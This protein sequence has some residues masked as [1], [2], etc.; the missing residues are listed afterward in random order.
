MSPPADPELK[1]VLRAVQRAVGERSWPSPAAQVV[2][3]SLLRTLLRGDEVP[4]QAAWAGGLG[5]G[6]KAL[7]TCLA[8]LSLGGL[9]YMVDRGPRP[10]AYLPQTTALEA[11]ARGQMSGPE[12]MALS[13][14]EGVTDGQ[15]S[16]PGGV[17]A[18][19]RA[20]VLSSSSSPISSASLDADQQRDLAAW[21]A[22][23]G[24]TRVDAATALAEDRFEKDV[25]RAIRIIREA[26]TKCPP[27]V[28][29]TVRSYMARG[30][31]LADLRQL[32]V[33]I[34]EYGHAAGGIAYWRPALDA[35][36]EARLEGANIV[37]IDDWLSRPPAME[38]LE[39]E[40]TWQ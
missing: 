27:A 4:A 5:I 21:K 37:Q 36:L 17:T 28:W 1:R 10:A 38:P 13:G 9:V 3:Q 7:Q 20:A 19:A 40:R 2:L 6:V 8:E 32:G 30:I 26:G 29:P 22:R 12:G 16:G 35:L 25:E 15:M 18:R 31:S 23:L 14:P 34:A 24:A 39:Q 11:W 33:R